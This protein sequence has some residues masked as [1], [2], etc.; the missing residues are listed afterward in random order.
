M[1]GAEQSVAEVGLG[2]A[3]ARCRAVARARARNFYYGLRLTPEPKRSGVYAMYA[4]MRAGDDL[5]DDAGDARAKRDALDR[6]ATA[7][8]QALSGV[9][10]AEP[11]PGAPEMWAAFSDT[12]ARFGVARE[13]LEAMLAGLAEDLDHTGYATMGDLRRYC[14]RVASSV[15]RVCVTIW[16]VRDGA[17]LDRARA[18]AD[19]R[20]VAFQLTN[21]LRDYAEDFDEGRVYLPAEAFER[22]GVTPGELRRWADPGACAALALDIARVARAEFEASAPLDGLIDPTCAPT[23]WAMTRIYSGLLAKIEARPERIAGRARVRLPSVRK[24]SIAVRA[25]ARSTR[26][27]W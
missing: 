11:A 22:R 21:I 26:G 19:R 10:P 20:G 3:Y 12:V 24:A 5:V 4:W 25:V 13:D 15:G 7:T 27:R 6:F 1:P 18:L 16:G 9:R 8:E 17:D 14:G 23:S 2:R